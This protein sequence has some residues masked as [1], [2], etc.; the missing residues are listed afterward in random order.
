MKD[1]ERRWQS[2]QSGMDGLNKRQKEEMQDEKLPEWMAEDDAR[3]K[4][5]QKDID[6]FSV[7]LNEDLRNRKAEQELLAFTLSRLSPASAYQLAAMSLGGTDI[8]VKSRYEDAMREYRTRFTRYVEEKEQASGGMGGFRIT[9]DTETGIK[10]SAPRERG[11]L[12]LSDLPVFAPPSLSLGEAAAPVVLDAGVLILSTL[13]AFA[14][15]VVA[16]LRYDIR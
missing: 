4:Q 16:F 12:D 3:R 9:V 8:R 15:A 11:S 6:E 5:V 14:G 10:F 7:R 13:L 2:R 1:L